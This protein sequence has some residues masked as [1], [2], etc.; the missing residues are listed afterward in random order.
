MPVRIQRKRTAGWRMPE[1]V[2]YVG[3]PSKWGNPFVAA[4]PAVAV[5][6][7]RRWITTN[8]TFWSAGQAGGLALAV[9]PGMR[10]LEIRSLLLTLAGVDLACW[11]PLDKPCHADVLLEI[12]NGFR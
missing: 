6:A 12:A 5:E 7:F 1:G 2:I 9:N 8:D 11:C 10:R 4:D 3:R